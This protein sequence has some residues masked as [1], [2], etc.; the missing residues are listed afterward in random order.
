MLLLV[1][2]NVPSNAI[3]NISCPGAGLSEYMLWTRVLIWIPVG[4]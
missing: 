4:V 1:K 3:E 2:A